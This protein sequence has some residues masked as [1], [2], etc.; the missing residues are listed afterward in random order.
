MFDLSRTTTILGHCSLWRS[1]S[2]LFCDKLANGAVSQYL[3]SGFPW[4]HAPQ[5]L[6]LEKAAIILDGTKQTTNV[7][8]EVR[9]HIGKEEGNTFYTKPTL[10]SGDT[11]KGELRWLQERFDQ[12]SWSSL[13]ASIRSKPNMFQVWLAKQCIG[14][15][16]T[17]LNMAQIQGLLDDNF[18]NCRH[19]KETN[20]HLNH[21]PDPGWTLLFRDGVA[22]ISRWMNKQSRTDAKHA[23]WVGKYLFF[24]GTHLFSSLVRTGGGR[25]SQLL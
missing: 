7:G 9:Y 1:N 11:N 12:V 15:Y 19:P 24:G 14:I 6:P 22:K 2:T 8:A 5:L 3:Q 4:I 10:I 18:F 17:R 25:L 13:D 23:Y 21:C 20:D 16:A